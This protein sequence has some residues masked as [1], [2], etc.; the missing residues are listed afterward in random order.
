L[1]KDD[2]KQSELRRHISELGIKD[3]DEKI[4]EE[5]LKIL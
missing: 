3:A 4:A 5:I 1:A 2:A